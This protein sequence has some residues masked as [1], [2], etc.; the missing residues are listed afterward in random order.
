MKFMKRSMIHALDRYATNHIDFIDAY[1][2]EHVKE[3]GSEPIITYN[4]KDFQKLNV[5]FYRPGQLELL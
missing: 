1:L 4:S 3:A 5:T 2:A